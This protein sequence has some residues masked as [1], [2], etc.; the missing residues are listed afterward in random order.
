M[1]QESIIQYIAATFAGIEMLRPDEGPGAGDSFIYYDPQGERDFSHRQPFATIVT[2]DYGE[3][4]NTSKLDRPGVYRL[5]ISLSRER[6]QELLGFP[7][8]Q[9][10][11]KR[12]DYDFAAPDQ[13]LPH[14]IY[15]VQ[16]WVS[17]L[18]PSQETFDATVKP[19]LAEAYNLAAQRYAS[20][21][22]PQG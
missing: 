10:D 22:A 21:Q 19:L 4:D 12:A 18:N 2:K 9:L 3:F 17:I 1:D 6:F 7:P 11:A 14:P 15:G 20:K 8:N 16:S 5:N 13:L